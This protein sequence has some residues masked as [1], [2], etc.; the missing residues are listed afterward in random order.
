MNYILTP[1]QKDVL[2][3]EIA[4]LLDAS[5]IKEVY[6]PDWL[7]NPVLVPKK[8]KDWRMC[9]DYTELNKACKKDMFGL[10]R[11]DQVVDSMAGCSL[12]SFLDCYSGY[13][14]IPLKQEDQIKTSFITPFDAFCYIMMSFR[15]KSAGAMYQR[16][17]Q[18]CLHSQ[19]GHNTEAYVDYVVIKTQEDE[20]LI[21]DLAE[22]FDNMRTFKMKLN[23][24]KCTFGVSSGKLLRYMVSHHGINPNP[25]KVSAI[26][27]MKPP[28]SLYDVQKLMGCMAALSRFIL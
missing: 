4:R 21:F 26:T 18:W 25:E 1:S 11:I 8:N 24:E 7:I 20:G 22:T 19:L 2:K 28:K 3:R 13:H 27:K 6:H 17:I 10:P 23:S 9:V 12:L 5:F 15:L 16:G 14:Q